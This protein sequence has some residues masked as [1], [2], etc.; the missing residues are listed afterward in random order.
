MGWSLGSFEYIL[1][2]QGIVTTL[3]RAVMLSFW[4]LAVR[5]ISTTLLF[6][7]IETTKTII[8]TADP[9]A[10]FNFLSSYGLVRTMI[11]RLFI[12]CVTYI[13]GWFLL[14]QVGEQLREVS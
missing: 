10:I 4:E 14:G 12:G 13:P 11:S 5:F 1:S 7:V 6:G 3:F 2:P 8:A 9:L